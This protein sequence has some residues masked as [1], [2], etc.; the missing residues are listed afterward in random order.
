V[1]KHAVCSAAGLHCRWFNYR[2]AGVR[3]KQ[4]TMHLCNASEWGPATRH[5]SEAW[6]WVQ[7]RGGFAGLGHQE[8]V[9]VRSLAH[10]GRVRQ[11]LAA[12]AA[13]QQ[14]PVSSPAWQRQQAR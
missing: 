2:M 5:T 1:A 6:E 11:G 7:E 14:V 4:L 9:A 13:Q 10:K 12:A 3:G 8:A